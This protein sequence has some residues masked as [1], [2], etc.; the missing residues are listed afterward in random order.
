MPR[1]ESA[2]MQPVPTTK[3]SKIQCSFIS[4]FVIFTIIT[5]LTVLALIFYYPIVFL[6][7]T[8][9]NQY[10]PTSDIPYYNAGLGG[11]QT[12]RYG[13]N[14]W[15]NASDVFRFTLPV[16]LYWTFI[17]VLIGNDSTV[18]QLWPPSIIFYLFVT[19]FFTFIEAAK[20]I[21]KI[22]DFVYCEDR[23]FC[24]NFNPNGIAGNAN[25]VFL[26]DMSYSIVFFVLTLGYVALGYVMLNTVTSF[27]IREKKQ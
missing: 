18:T 14:W 1:R 12:N 19:I 23:N 10:L 26:T 7:Y 20:M 25:Y 8:F 11:T 2:L 3:A 21:L 13:G 27:T 5:S 6:N 16:F 22:V 17:W 9:T 15:V 4:I 24:R